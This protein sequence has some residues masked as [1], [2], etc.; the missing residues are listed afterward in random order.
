MCVTLGGRIA[1][2]IIFNEISTG[3]QDDLEKV[4]KLAYQQIT[5]YGFSEKVGC[6]SF[7][8]YGEDGN[9]NTLYSEGKKFLLF[10]LFILF[11]FLLF[12]LFLFYLFFIKQKKYKNRQK[13]IG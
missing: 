6:L 4:T 2:S 13:R 5:V 10:L 9:H 11:L 8:N 12:F 7:P 1:E 3:A